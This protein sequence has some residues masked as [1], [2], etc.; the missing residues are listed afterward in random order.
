MGTALPTTAME[1]LA[2][3][4]VLIVSTMIYTVSSLQCYYCGYRKIDGGEDELL[5]DLPYSDDFLQTTDILVNCTLP[6]DCCASTKEEVD[7]LDENGNVGRTE[8]IAKHGCGSDMGTIEGRHPYCSEHQDSCFDVDDS[9]LPS[10]SPSFVVTNIEVCFCSTDRCN[11]EEPIF[12]EP[13]PAPGGA[14]ATLASI[15]LV[16]LGTL[17]NIA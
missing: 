10:P 13:A 9:T 16:S 8:I 5:P 12:P 1:K 7:M 6:G 17:L 15:V 4:N 2:L 11:E 14:L 3:I